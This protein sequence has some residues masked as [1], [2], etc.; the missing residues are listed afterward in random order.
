M[1]KT[2]CIMMAIL[3]LL[4]LTA[5]CGVPAATETVSPSASAEA[6]AV[7]TFA[8]PVLEARVRAAMGRPEG[9]I[10][11]AEAEAVTEMYLGL[12]WQ[13][14]ISEET[15][16][17]DLGGLEYFKNLQSLN[18][19]SNAVT[20]ISPLAGLIK[21][22]SLSLGGNQVADI[23]PLSGMTGLEKLSLSG[24]TAEDFSP[25]ESLASLTVLILDDS[26]ITDLSALSGLTG[27]AY[28]SLKDTQ[29]S[30]VSPL[31]GLTGLKQLYLSECPVDDYSP[32][33][34]IYANLEEKDFTIPSSLEEL[35]F[36]KPDNSVLATYSAEG[37][38]ITVNH[39][40]WGIP[41]MDM[42][43]DT[44]R[45]YLDMDDGYRLTVGCD[46]AGNQNY[47]FNISQNGENITDY[48]YITFDDDLWF[49]GD[50]ERVE[51]A[52]RTM[53]GDTDS[54]DILLAPITVYN[55]TIEETFGMTADKL[56]ALP[57]ASPTLLNLGFTADQEDACYF[58]DQHDPSYY[59]IE[60]NNPEWGN[61]DEG[62]DVR[63]FTPLSDEYRIVIY[64]YVDEKKFTVGVDDNDGGGASYEYFAE[65]DEHTDVWCS[66]DEMTVEQ[67]FENA[68]NDPEIEDVYLYPVQLMQQYISD[69]FGMTIDE[70]YALPVGE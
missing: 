15:Q 38:T 21:L 8:D 30:D 3:M 20:D 1:K 13:M 28:L 27:L 7:V 14:D 22:T 17:T 37:L 62:G 59:S 60:V 53:L 10:T 23:S 63:F 39:S 16:I 32:L 44:I 68:I 47:V 29:V 46:P 35:G 65:T 50:R 9:D 49:D 48:I 56:F 67:Y 19:S 24:C 25:L 42:E 69:T 12:E 66:N 41:E 51:D 26:A 34:D 33:A 4:V 54:G 40:E 70:L 61:W 11:I 18:L 36:T 6:S 2:L 45:L 5:A 52:I 43:A 31:S 55:D 57:F 64:Y 58:Y